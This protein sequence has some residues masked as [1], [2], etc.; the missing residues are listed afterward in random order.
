M[1][2]QSGG[3]PKVSTRS[4]PKSRVSRSQR[5]QRT[6]QY[7]CINKANYTGAASKANCKKQTGC[8][9]DLPITVAQGG[10]A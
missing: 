10:T 1:G 9:S 3:T 8:S 2:E 7:S 6:N 4:S 5:S